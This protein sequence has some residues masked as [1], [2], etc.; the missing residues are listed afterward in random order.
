MGDEVEEPGNVLLKEDQ[1][2]RGVMLLKDLPNPSEKGQ[3]VR[4]GGQLREDNLKKAEYGRGDG[5]AEWGAGCLRV[6][7]NW[8]CFAPVPRMFGKNVGGR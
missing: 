1:V 2:I 7:H 4:K 6:G 3:N 8:S 5:L